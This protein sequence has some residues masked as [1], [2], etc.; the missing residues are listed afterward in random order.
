MLIR[1]FAGGNGQWGLG[2]D[3]RLVEA[4]LKQ[5][6][7]GMRNA[8]KAGADW[9]IEQ[10]DPL[11]WG[12]RTT[13]ADLHIYLEVPCRL[14]FPWAAYNVVVVNQE[15]W[16]LTAWNWCLEKPENGGADLFVFKSQHAMKHFSSLDPARK[17]L[18]SWRADTPVSHDGWTAR[19][20]R[21]LYIVGGS[22]NKARIAGEIVRLWKDSYPPVEVWCSSP[23]ARGLQKCVT[24]SNVT[25]QTEYKSTEEKL[26]R[27]RA[28]KWHVVASAAEG[29]GFTMAEAAACGAPVLWND[30]PVYRESWGLNIGGFHADPTPSD[31]QMRDSYR[32]TVDEA[33]MDRAVLELVNIT[34]DDVK[35]LQEK[36]RDRITASRD[37]FLNGWRR[38]VQRM[39]QERH[40]PLLPKQIPKGA[41]LPKVGLIT[42]TRNR[43][44]WWSN[45]VGS[46]MN[47]LKSWPIN[48]LEWIVVDDSDPV[49]RVDAKVERF[50]ED[51][52]ALSVK[53]V[54]LTEVKTVGE[55]RNLAVQAASPD[56]EV[57]ACVDD[58]DHYPPGSLERRVSWLMTTGKG[59]TY[60][61]SL[62]M[63]D[64]T[65]YI[66]AMNVPPL[67][68]EPA[69]R[70]SEA[71]LTFTRRFW[72][73]KGF[74]AVGM[75]E[76]EGFIRGRE[77]AA[78][79]IPPYGIIVSFIHKGNTSSRRTPADQEPN[80]SHYGFS[81]KYFEY[82]H[83]VG[84]L[85]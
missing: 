25:F 35:R 8:V 21:F 9:L 67:I 27:Q 56:V 79:E 28:C 30:L 38:V 40:T 83:T 61:S 84:G 22:Q 33:D 58:D 60:C 69:Q 75:A 50:Q 42:V 34:P 19:E 13:P 18:L 82:I 16:P 36:Y 32:T 76:G 54:S 31:V 46:V 65:R 23:I 73:E 37:G 68:L 49:G 66:S 2:H 81:D 52:P 85:E 77:G 4:V 24:A 74:P 55:K 80:G 5:I 39:T 43:A 51:L 62:P 57:F 29:Y 15:W 72:E 11:T 17:L 41:Y 64:I 53:Y 3:S 14:A 44:D 78:V 59:A 26:Q 1:I 12:N 48:R 63:Y 7:L 10:C 20:D 70:I 71:T 47:T 6:R 45:M